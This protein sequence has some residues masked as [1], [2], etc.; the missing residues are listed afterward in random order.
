MWEREKKRNARVDPE[1]CW[2]NGE[3]KEKRRE[4]KTSS[5]SSSYLRLLSLDP[6]FFVRVKKSFGKE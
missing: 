2:L 6:A 4:R 1:I 3:E 5:S